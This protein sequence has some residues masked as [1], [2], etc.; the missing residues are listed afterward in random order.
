MGDD[1][2]A[3]FQRALGNFVDKAKSD[4][5]VV[6]AVVFGS[7]VNDEV[8]EK[9]DIDLI[10]VVK[11]VKHVKP[12]LA[13]VEEDV[14]LHVQVHTRDRFKKAMDRHTAGGFLHSMLA[15][16]KVLFTRDPVID[17]LH[18]QAQQDL[19]TRDQRAQLFAA[20]SQVVP[21]LYKAQ[22]FCLLK[23]DPEHAFV[24]IAHLYSP[25]AKIEVYSHKKLARREAIKQALE[26][27]PDFFGPIYTELLHQKKT[28]K[29]VEAALASI[30]AYL[31]EHTERLFRPLLDFLAEAGS[32]RSASAIQE[33]GQRQLGIDGTLMACEWLSDKGI[34]T[35]V[36]SPIRATKGSKTT[37]DELAFFHE[38]EPDLGLD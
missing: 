31:S 29:R 16:G 36:A 21:A 22:K 7:L 2:H 10:L 34:V 5:N 26:L 33:W 20:A 23:R 9:S 32:A 17:Q 11:D 6:A 1:V 30:D 28:Q 38:P 27:N 35:K 18:A 19:G 4:H 13:L 37:Y 14:N 24:W 12:V 8:W 25:L 15:D 3:R